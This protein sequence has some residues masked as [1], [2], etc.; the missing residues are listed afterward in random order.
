MGVEAT[1]PDSGSL[2]VP[3]ELHGAR[4][5]SILAK[6]APQH[7]RARWQN[8]INEG[9]VYING[10]PALKVREKMSAG[11]TIT[12]REPPL[13][14]VELVPEDR[15]LKILFEDQHL[16]VVD[17]PAGMVIHPAPGH[18]AGTL[19]HALLHHCPDLRGVGG[20]IRPGIVHRLDRD[21]S[22][23]LVVAKN[24]LAHRQL[25]EQFK[26]RQVKKQYLALVYGQP[27]PPS[28]TIETMIGRSP[29]RRDKMSARVLHGRLAR[30]HYRTLATS[31]PGSLLLV[32]IETGRTHQI[33]V[34]MAHIGYPVVGD[35]MYGSRSL[36]NRK[37]GAKRQMLHAWRIGFFHPSSLELMEFE[38]PLPSDFREMARKLGIT[39]SL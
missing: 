8:I 20:E 16:I 23:V 30:T 15:P 17:K 10:R 31:E 13:R 27:E 1:A 26:T 19:V 25:A 38:S 3:P 37:F 22:G 12:W 29:N 21:T 35:S 6:L 18:D 5:D 14:P 34:H 2:I 33:R 4:L 11:D 32:Q 28:G 36:L 39:Y 24:E 7:S 9:L